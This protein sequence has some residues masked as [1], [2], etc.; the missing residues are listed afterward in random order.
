MSNDLPPRG[1][2][3]ILFLL[4]QTAAKW[5]E[6]HTSQLAAAL[7]YYAI[8][9]LAPTLIVII[10]IAG[11]FLGPQAVQGY[12]VAE[13]ES[14][15]GPGAAR[16]IE[17]LLANISQPR[18]NILATIIGVA[19]IL[20]GATNLFNQLKA[21]LNLIWKVAPSPELG[22]LSILRDRL[23]AFL[24]L[25]GAG[26]LLLASLLINTVVTSINAHLAHLLP[27]AIDTLFLV[28][29]SNL[30]LSFI[31]LAIAFGIIFKLLPDAQVAW[32]DVIVGALV[33]ALLFTL[34]IFL[35]SYYLGNFSPGS[36]YG[37]A[38]SLV[39]LLLWIY[40]SAQLFLLGAQFTQAYANHYGS[41]IRPSAR[42]V[43]IIRRIG[44]PP[45]APEEGGKTG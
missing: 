18:S 39:V 42:G 12:I 10:G 25:L 22:F 24:M 27:G 9:S 15:V 7:A 6:D 34:G 45:A 26:A 32:Q 13:M 35:I 28:R 4:Q 30:L 37:A 41:E 36:A 23:L 17:S 31:L 14:L 40:Y 8:F 33:T 1:A 3:A 5:S 20:Y 43:P 29:V 16:A 44:R 19:M 38:G 2:R 11:L 21:S